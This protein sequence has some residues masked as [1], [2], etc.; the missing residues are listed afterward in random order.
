MGR[1]DRLSEGLS[2]GRAAWVAIV[3]IA[4]ATPLSGQ[5]SQTLPATNAA[6]KALRKEASDAVRRVVKDFSHA[7]R[8]LGLMGNLH[9]SLGNTAEAVRCW[10]RCIELDPKGIDSY[11]CIAEAALRSGNFD[12]AVAMTRRGLKVD[13]AARGLNGQL[14]RALVRL[15]KPKEAIPALLRDVQ[16]SPRA[17]MSH[18]ALGH[19]YQ[20]L[21]EFGKAKESFLTAMRIYPA[22]T[23]ACYG[24]A[25]VCARLGQKDEAAKYRRKLKQ[26][27]AQDW[28]KL[29][30]VEQ[31]ART[32]RS[33]ALLRRRVTWIHTQ[34]GIVYKDGGRAAEAEKHWLRAAE[35]DPKATACRNELGALY[36]RTRRMDKA[37]EMSRQL[38]AIKPD[39][40]RYHYGHAVL[41]AQMNRLDAALA[42]VERAVRLDPNNAAALK[43][44]RQIRRMKNK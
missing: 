5:P 27:K 22:Y 8:P 35:L 9:V 42:A 6:E 38:L 23:E 39:N 24:L 32:I 25:V 19:A 20:Q 17:S 7:A 3:I 28:A 16:I 4:V 30:T 10:E 40:T 36:R 21:R 41:L 31:T 11:R 2:A 18:L 29:P 13:P 15:G 1:T 12:K 43:L 37:L 33:V 14:G 44:Y 26:M 34:I